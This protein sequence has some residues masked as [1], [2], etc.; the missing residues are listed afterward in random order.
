VYGRPLSSSPAAS[1]ISLPSLFPSTVPAEPISAKWLMIEAL[2][3]P[4][5]DPGQTVS[6]RQNDLT[7]LDLIAEEMRRGLAM[8]A[9][10][11]RLARDRDAEV[12]TVTRI[13]GFFKCDK[14]LAL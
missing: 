1:L 12:R 11:R 9:D 14:P 4:Q 3:L 6:L 5:A 8:W 2:P 10:D 7:P 13:N